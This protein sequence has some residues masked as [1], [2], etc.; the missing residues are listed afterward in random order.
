DLGLRML[1]LKDSPI[2][3]ATVGLNRQVTTVA[4]FA[5]SAGVAGVGGALYGAAM[6]RPSPDAF[7]FFGGLS[8]LVVVV[9]FGVS[10][11][12]SPVAAGTFLAAPFLVNIFPSLAQVTPT[13][14]AA[15]GVGLGD[16]PN[17][18]IPSNLRP[19]W[20]GLLR[21]PQ[22]LWGGLAA[23]VVVYLATL[24]GAI[25]NWAFAG[26]CVVFAVVMPAAS[27]GLGRSSGGGP[28][29]ARSATHSDTRSN[30]ISDSPERLALSLPLADADVAALDD[31]FGV[32]AGV[33]AGVTAGTGF[34]TGA[35][36]GS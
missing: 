26:F 30:G 7:N 29:V 11:L 2:G 32:R 34:T 4:A 36:R 33:G 25:S 24:T 21:Q 6:Q 1:A 35:G 20:S 13:M 31:M 18:A 10:S 28:S 23:L 19:G 9:V 14:T 15:A 3:Y 17:G 16:N 22:L 12:G 5:I 8:I 27:Q